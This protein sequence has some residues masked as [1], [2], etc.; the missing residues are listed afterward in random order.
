MLV[1]FFDARDVKPVRYRTPENDPGFD[2]C[3]S[4]AEKDVGA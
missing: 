2:C 3:L 4:L 1:D